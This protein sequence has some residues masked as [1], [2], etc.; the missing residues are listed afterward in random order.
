M[1]QK[2]TMW[3]KWWNV[4]TL[5]IYLRKCFFQTD[6]SLSHYYQKDKWSSAFQISS[7]RRKPRKCVVE[8]HTDTKA[9]T[10]TKT[11]LCF[12]TWMQNLIEII[13]M[14]LSWWTVSRSDVFD[15]STYTGIKIV[16]FKYEKL[17]LKFTYLYTNFYLFSSFIDASFQLFQQFWTYIWYQLMNF[18]ERTLC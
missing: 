8:L 13:K 9:Q 1:M 6:R 5:Y 11:F 2:K 15:D 14:V 12:H 7:V 3:K 10:S 18:F 4:S 16:S 17:K